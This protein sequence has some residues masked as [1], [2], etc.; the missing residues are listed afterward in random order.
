MIK[1]IK[2]ED[3]KNIISS[4]TPLFTE[5]VASTV[6]KIAESI[7]THKDKALKEYISKYDGVELENLLINLKD[8]EVPDL[9]E[10][11]VRAFRKA[12]ENIY[13]YHKKQ[14]RNSWF[15]YTD[16]GSILGQKIIPLEKVG[17]YVPGG[18]ASY[19]STVLM[20]VIPA[21]IAGVK[22]II[23]ATPPM[24]D[25]EINPYT[26]FA[27]KETG[28][29]K[30]LKAGGA[31]AVCAMAFGTESIPKVDKIVGPGNKYVTVAKKYV[32]GDVDIDMLAGP[33]EVLV[34]ADKT[35]NPNYIAA[36]MLS[37]AEHDPDAR[38]ILITTDGA[39]AGKVEQKI[40][41]MI[42]RLK[43]K[44]IIKQSIE[45]NGVILI[46]EDIDEA[47]DLANRIAPEHLEIL[48]EKPFEHLCKIKHAGAV[49]LG[50][51]SPE[52]LGDYYAGPN[53]VLPTSGT[54]R[55]NSVLSVDDFVRKTSVIYYSKE[56]FVKAREDVCILAESEGLDA[57]MNSI[58]V[59][60][61]K[62]NEN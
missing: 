19:P 15:E 1:T 58:K 49:F 12:R 40:I 36:D 21:K 34:I 41:E 55:F 61:E 45:N 51:Y 46:A 10:K 42:Q 7:K 25:G 14:L 33:S 53:H 18:R 37:Q 39:I 48:T 62:I 5:E 57:H 24:A 16:T 8:I 32:Y 9:P 22:E 3:F 20:T 2:V 29:D 11:F 52:P 60:G 4:S 44:E 27:A 17:I 54:A 38:A 43:R 30:I 26:L 47:I 50:E 59:R 13:R 35:A 28:V 31:H 6:K 56:D 23:M